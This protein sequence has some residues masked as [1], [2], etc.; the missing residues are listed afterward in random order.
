MK[1]TKQQNII[2][3]NAV[4]IKRLSCFYILCYHTY[5]KIKLNYFLHY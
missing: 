5:L 1:Q 3:A 4:D 2:D